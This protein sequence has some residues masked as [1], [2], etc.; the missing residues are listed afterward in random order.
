MN[1]IRIV[2]IL[3][4]ILVAICVPVAA[5][6]AQQAAEYRVTLDATWSATSHPDA[7]PPD[8]HFSP[9]IGAVHDASYSMWGPGEI[10]S[11]GIEDMA[12]D[13]ATTFLAIEI[14]GA[15]NLGQAT[16]LLRG[17]FL[18]AGESGGDTFTAQDT[19]PLLT[20]VSMIAPSPDWFVGVHGLDL[21]PGGVWVDRLD[22]ELHAYDAG[23]DSGVDF[24]SGDADTQPRQPITDFAS[25]V[26][27]AATPHVAVLVIER[28]DAPPCIGDLTTAGATIAGQPGFGVPDGL[29]DLDDLGFYLN[30]WLAIDLTVADLT[31]SAGTLGG[32]PGFGIP[33]GVVDL[34]DLGFFLNAWLAG[35][36]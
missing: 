18:F 36:P 28:T 11:D 6:S 30:A 22:I 20:V 33:D 16:D 21:R 32:Q 2:P 15:R 9:F 26:P 25:T 8:A 29:A 13:G 24:L 35:C 19:H 23:T 10:A 5:A 1:Q 34:D 7:F 17:P 27:F 14:A 31:T 12:E 3:Q 4:R